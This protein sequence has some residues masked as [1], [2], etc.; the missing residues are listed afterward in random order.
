MLEFMKVKLLFIKS[1][2]F[3]ALTILSL[4]VFLS[5]INLSKSLNWLR[6]ITA[7]MSVGLRLYPEL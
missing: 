6:P 3:K 7:D 1:F 4:F 2:F 5:L